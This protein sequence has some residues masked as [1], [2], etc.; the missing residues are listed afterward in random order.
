[1]NFEFAMGMA[2]SQGERSLLDDLLPVGC[3]VVKNEEIIAAARRHSQ[4]NDPF[5]DH[6]E[7]Q[8]LKQAV[9]GLSY[10]ACR[11]LT[12]FTTLEPCVMCFGTIL[13]CKLG[14]VMY[15][16]EDPYAGGCSSS[17]WS[18]VPPR[19]QAD[20]PLITEG[21]LRS[22]VRDLFQQYFTTTQNLFW[23][24]AKDNPLVVRCLGP[25]EPILRRNCIPEPN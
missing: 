21:I 25:E 12:L 16:L 7:V 20:F 1:M 11:E 14:S 8:A 9:K 6:A 2:I 18:D 13:H 4:E 15:A 17:R 3:V 24:N 22:K 5:F 10:R 23:R 19:H